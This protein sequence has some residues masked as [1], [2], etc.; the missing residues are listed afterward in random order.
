ML[1]ITWKKMWH[2][3]FAMQRNIGA[4][5]WTKQTHTFASN[6]NLH[7]RFCVY[8]WGCVCKHLQTWKQ[9]R[10]DPH[11]NAD[12]SPIVDVLGWSRGDFCSGLHIY[13]DFFLPFAWFH[14]NWGRFFILPKTSYP[15]PLWKSNGAPLRGITVPTWDKSPC[16]AQRSKVGGVCVWIVSSS[17]LN[18]LLS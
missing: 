10:I 8:V 9:T 1:I 11:G 4:L 14:R 5:K 17:H 16:C 12:T 2:Q 7:Y 13:G 18:R 15:P 6:N 3:S